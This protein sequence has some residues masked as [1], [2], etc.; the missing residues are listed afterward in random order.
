MLTGPWDVT[1]LLVLLGC[2]P[3]LFLTAARA[4]VSPSR[5]QVLI[6]ISTAL[7]VVAAGWEVLGGIGRNAPPTVPLA[8]LALAE[9]VGIAGG[10]WYLRG[11]G[12]RWNRRTPGEAPT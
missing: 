2:A 9:V 4:V 11:P 10:W 5:A 1:R 6:S 7:M 12:N 8:T 3:L